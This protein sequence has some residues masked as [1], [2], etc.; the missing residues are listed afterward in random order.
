MERKLWHWARTCTVGLIYHYSWNSLLKFNIKSAG[1]DRT[2]SLFQ[3]L[4]FSTF[5]LK[6][7]LSKLLAFII[8]IKISNRPNPTFKALSTYINMTGNPTMANN[9]DHHTAN[10]NHYATQQSQKGKETYREQMPSTTLEA[11]LTSENPFTFISLI[12]LLRVCIAWN[13]QFKYRSTSYRTDR[14]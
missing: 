6:H 14:D 2:K 4:I 1:Q 13:K 9:R 12:N 3:A 10:T 5:W 7:P 11:T 8:T